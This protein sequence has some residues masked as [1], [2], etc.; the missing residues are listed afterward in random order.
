M[1]LYAWGT[2][3]RSEE[4]QLYLFDHFASDWEAPSKWPTQVTKE[5]AMRKGL[6]AFRAPGGSR[7]E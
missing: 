6:V 5:Q 3:K 4:E 1:R 2:T 7:E